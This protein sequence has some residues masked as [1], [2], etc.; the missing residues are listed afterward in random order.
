ML[1]L[2][3]ICDVF[4]LQQIPRLLMT[5]LPLSCTETLKQ[6]STILLSAEVN[7]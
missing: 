1:D 2:V 7:I 5:L 3:G 6:D 4:Q